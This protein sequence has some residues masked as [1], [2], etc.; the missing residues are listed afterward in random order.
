MAVQTT[1]SES[2]RP[3]LSKDVVV[4]AAIEMAD[5]NGLEALSMRKLAQRLGVEAMSLYHYFPN[6]SDIYGGMLEVVWQEVELPPP[7]D[8][9]R[10]ALRKSAVSAYRAL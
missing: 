5:A 8:D 9:W 4:K 7:G 1:K 3:R 6:K 10:S 2:P